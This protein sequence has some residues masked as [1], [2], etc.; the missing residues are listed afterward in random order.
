MAAAGEV[1]QAGPGQ[2]DPA[3]REWQ[4]AYA[5]RSFPRTFVTMSHQ[6]SRSGASAAMQLQLVLG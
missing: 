1:I 2:R 6:K 5:C 4:S 3:A